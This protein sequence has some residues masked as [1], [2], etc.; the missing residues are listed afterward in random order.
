MSRRKTA[1][2]VILPAFAAVGVAT[3]LHFYWYLLPQPIAQWW[4]GRLIRNEETYNKRI[5]R[6]IRVLGGR[7]PWAGRYYAGDGLGMN[8]AIELAP[9]SGYTATSHGDVG[10]MTKERG[11]V[12]EHD[13]RLVFSNGWS[14]YKWV[15]RELVI[16]RWS[17]RT[18]LIPPDRMLSFANAVNSGMEP[19]FEDHGM[20]LL[21]ETDVDKGATGKPSIPPE[22]RPYLLDHPIEAVITATGTASGLETTIRFNVGRREGVLTGMA[23]QT[24]AKGQIGEAT[25]TL[26]GEHSCEA[27]FKRYLNTEPAPR[28]GGR[29]SAGYPGLQDPQRNALAKLVDIERLSNKN[30]PPLRN[31]YPEFISSDQ[32][33]N[34]AAENGFTIIPIARIKMK[35]KNGGFISVYGERS[36]K[37][38]NSLLLGIGANAYRELQ[39][40]FRPTK[41][42]E[43]SS[44]VMAYRV[45]YEG[46]ALESGDFVDRSSRA[47]LDWA[48]SRARMRLKTTHYYKAEESVRLDSIRSLLH[49]SKDEF[50]RFQDLFVEDLNPEQKRAFER[51]WGLRDSDGPLS[52]ARRAPDAETTWHNAVQQI[53]KPREGALLHDAYRDDALHRDYDEYMRLKRI[54][55]QY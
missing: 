16:V 8:D 25:A 12:V 44:E 38:R 15:P 52:K 36:T 10:D 50:E 11:S 29:L 54:V 33:F 47:P 51:Y 31:I 13:G 3:W 49:L 40:K 53:L 1:L 34:G 39:Y 23:F 26:I 24:H 18:Y 14:E 7:H 17:A 19:R 20:F 55:Y 37:P 43:A 22:F 9:E 27:L 32:A 41:R 28:V 2:A 42:W 30:Y 35:A 48:A 21:R 4:A 45:E 46:R 5:A 6:E